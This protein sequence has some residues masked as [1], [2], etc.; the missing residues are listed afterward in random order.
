M[1]YDWI[2]ELFYLLGKD[3]L[4]NGDNVIAVERLIG[5]VRVKCDSMQVRS[6]KIIKNMMLSLMQKL[7]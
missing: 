4:Y 3:V 1:D 2:A 7:L 5:S 6:L